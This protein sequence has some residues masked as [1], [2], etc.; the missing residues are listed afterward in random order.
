[1]KQSPL[2]IG[3]FK[4]C[5]NDKLIFTNSRAKVFNIDEIKD[6]LVFYFKSCMIRKK[7]QHIK[8]SK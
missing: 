3:Y 8:P 7:T 1:M 2:G 4:L 6:K 5:N